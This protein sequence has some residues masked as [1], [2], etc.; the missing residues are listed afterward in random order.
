[1]NR[2][3][4]QRVPILFP[5]V[6]MILSLWVHAQDSSMTTQAKD[7]KLA[8][9]APA[10]ANYMRV[11]SWQ[12][13]SL[14]GV[15]E[16]RDADGFVLRDMKG[17]TYLVTVTSNTQ[18]KEKKGNPFRKA[19]IYGTTQLLRGLEVEVSGRGT[20]SGQIEAREVKF[21]DDDF[22]VAKVVETRVNPVEDQLKST[23]GQ[24]RQTEQNAQRLSGQLEEVG[25]ISNAAKRGAQ[26]AQQSADNAMRACRYC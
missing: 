22:R 8:G 9:Q 3:S 19:R 17:N 24:L 18:I 10:N 26:N 1:M 23:E 13:A 16:S 2:N 7:D 15:V 20:E 25:S 21:R 4:V 6:L 5:A 12:S 11:P 14:E